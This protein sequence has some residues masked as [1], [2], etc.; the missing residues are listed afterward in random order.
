MCP[1]CKAS[2]SENRRSHQRPNVQTESASLLING[3]ATVENGRNYGT[4]NGQVPAAA[5][6][7][8][9]GAQATPPSHGGVVHATDQDSSVPVPAEKV[10]GNNATVMA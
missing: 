4:A 2:I 7:G 3:D 6:T 1:L 5:P 10:D 8:G 9:E